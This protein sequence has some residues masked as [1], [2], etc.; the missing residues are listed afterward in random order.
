MAG[1]AATKSA[2]KKV[3]GPGSLHNAT[4]GVLTA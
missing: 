3:A 1:T 4:H 2:T